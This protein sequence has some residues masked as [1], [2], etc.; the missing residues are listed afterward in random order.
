[1]RRDEEEKERCNLNFPT[2]ATVN[3]PP[4]SRCAWWS[5]WVL[6]QTLKGLMPEEQE[7]PF[8]GVYFTESKAEAVFRA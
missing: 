6:V 8:L 1:M 3:L 2:P 7:E 5:C 4:D